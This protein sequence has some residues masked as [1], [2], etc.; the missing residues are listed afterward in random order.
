MARVDPSES[1][2]GVALSVDSADGPLDPTW[3]I[4]NE[5]QDCGQQTKIQAPGEV[6]I[7]FRS[8]S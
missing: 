8:A 1:R 6:E 5:V 3:K 4:T 2:A 7:F